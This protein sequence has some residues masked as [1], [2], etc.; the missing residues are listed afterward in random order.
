MHSEAL[1]SGLPLHLPYCKTF[2]HFIIYLKNVR[3][4][5][6]LMH[7]VTAVYNIVVIKKKFTISN[8]I[9]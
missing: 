2:L 3:T 9:N 7:T 1:N 8:Y 6:L 4:Q 5:L